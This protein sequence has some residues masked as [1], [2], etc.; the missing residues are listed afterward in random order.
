MFF[1]HQSWKPD[2]LKYLMST[3]NLILLISQ[4]NLMKNTIS[5]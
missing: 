4:E 1:Q 2:T 3:F 5:N